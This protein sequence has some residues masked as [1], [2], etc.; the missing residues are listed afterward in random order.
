MIVIELG[1]KV[2]DSIT[3]FKGTATARCVYLNGCIQYEITSSSL[4]DGAPLKEWF[5]EGQLKVVAVK[6]PAQKAPR[7]RPG[8]PQSHAPDMNHP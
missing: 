8:G 3:G 5:D 7:D 1:S 4:K 2:K 6:K